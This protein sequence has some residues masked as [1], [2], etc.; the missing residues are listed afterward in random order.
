MGQFATERKTGEKAYR[1]FV[2][3][4]IGAESIWKDLTAQSILGEPDY[5]E[6]M[7]NHVKGK[8]RIADIPKSQ[9]FISRP[10][11]ENLFAEQAIREK[12]G[13]DERIFDSVQ[14]HG[15]TQEDVADYLGLHFASV[16]RIMRTKTEM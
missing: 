5:V 7:S 9:R 16:S 10:T 14:R 8:E 1:K 11:L 13:R 3:D 2:S 4:G 6:S 15:Y 12:G